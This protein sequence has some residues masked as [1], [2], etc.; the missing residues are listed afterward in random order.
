MSFDLSQLESAD[1]VQIIDWVQSGTISSQEVY[2]Y[3]LQKTKELN[4]KL[5]AFIEIYD[6][7]R[8]ADVDTLLAGLP[9]GIKDVFNEKGKLTQAA[10]KMLE[11]YIAPYDATTI[12]KLNEAGMSSLGTLNMDEFA[13]GGSGERSAFGPALNPHDMTRIPGGSSSGSAVAVA[14]GMVPAALGT[15]T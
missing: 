6:T 10:S 14:A 5:N 12:S 9:L 13:M 1:L 7:Q 11:G 8:V 3:F 4:P 15:D 2:L